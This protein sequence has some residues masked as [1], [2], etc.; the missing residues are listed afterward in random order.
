MARKEYETIEVNEDNEEIF[1][2]MSIIQKCLFNEINGIIDKNLIEER[3]H[4]VH[5]KN[6][7]ISAY[8]SPE[9][10]TTINSLRGN[11][12][13]SIFCRM[14]ISDFCS[15]I[16]ENGI[17]DKDI[18]EERNQIVRSSNLVISAHISPELFT[19]IDCLRGKNSRSSFFRMAVSEFCAAIEEI[20]FNSSTSENSRNAS[21]N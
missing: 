1:A 19:I 20:G 6:P 4:V 16:Q 5:S 10:F 9:L 11:I 17:N 13:R 8:V 12:C 7:V 14:A 2:K 21:I 3:N 18:I 15:V